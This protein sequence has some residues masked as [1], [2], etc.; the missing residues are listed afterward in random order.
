MLFLLAHKVE[1]SVQCD[2][3]TR[4]LPVKTSNLFVLPFHLLGLQV[5]TLPLRHENLRWDP[6]SF[7]EFVVSSPQFCRT[8]CHKKY[9]FSILL[10]YQD[11][12]FFWCVH[13]FQFFKISNQNISF[14]NFLQR[15]RHFLENSPVILSC[16]IDEIFAWS[17]ADI[18]WYS[19]SAQKGTMCPK[20]DSPKP[21]SYGVFPSA[22]RCWTFRR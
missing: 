13:I 17:I 10:S 22:R 4:N 7:L 14:P 2:D 15:S 9:K 21:L 12:I 1:L 18:G 5:E 19:T 11:R 20:N 16:Q 3:G 6:R 8:I